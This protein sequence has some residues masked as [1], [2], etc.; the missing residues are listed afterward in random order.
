MSRIAEI[1]KTAG[2]E[3]YL[4]ES[5]IIEEHA[6]KNNLDAVAL[7]NR[8]ITREP[9]QYII[10]EW[11]F[12]GDAYKLNRDCL[13]P[14][15]ETE[16]LTEYIINNAKKD[17]LILDLCSGSGCV[18]ISALKRREDLSAVLVDISNGAVNIAKENAHTNAVAERTA[19]YCLD[20]M[21]NVSEICELVKYAYNPPDVLIACNPPYLTLSEVQEVRDERTELSHEPEAALLGGAD[22]L[23]FY[24]FIAENYKNICR[25]MIFEC[26]R[27]QHESITSILQSNGFACSVMKDYAKIER[28]IAANK[29]HK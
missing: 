11:E 10:G 21:I 26:G 27:N 8:R 20:V 17:T 9:L 15:P 13:I 14:R 24:R 2:I 3:N 4:F 19:H 29:A 6:A 23:D 22:G 7:T 1:L 18:S 5:R 12:Y 25:E 16:F 28:I